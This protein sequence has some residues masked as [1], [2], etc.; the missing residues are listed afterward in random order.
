M[1]LGLATALTITTTPLCAE[2]EAMAKHE[3]TLTAVQSQRV[4]FR[5]HEAGAF[6]AV[7]PPA[8][9]PLP[10]F[11]SLA[12]MH[13]LA[14]AADARILAVCGRRPLVAVRKEGRG[15]VMAVA[16]TPLGL[17]ADDRSWLETHSYLLRN[18]LPD[19]SERH[20]Q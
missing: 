18:L 19:E 11:G 10:A 4:H 2:R 9:Q 8:S 12:W 5:P 13:D 3:L 7:Q 14:P 20:K 17:P 1:A 6:Q 16:A 15:R